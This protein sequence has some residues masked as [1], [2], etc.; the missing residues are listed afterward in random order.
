MYLCV[1]RYVGI[2]TNLHVLHNKNS[3]VMYIIYINTYFACGCKRSCLECLD[4]LNGFPL[5]IFGAGRVTFRTQDRT[6]SEFCSNQ[7]S[8]GGIDF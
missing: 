8:P 2:C 6:G 5:H 3:I 4:W 7:W 1:D